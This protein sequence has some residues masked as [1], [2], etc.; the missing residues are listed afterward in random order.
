MRLYKIIY[1]YKGVIDSEIVYRDNKP[2]AIKKFLKNQN[3]TDLVILKVI[4]WT[5]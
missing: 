5:T 2:E 3:L 1:N 4:E